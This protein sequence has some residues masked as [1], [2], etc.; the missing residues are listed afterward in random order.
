MDIVFVY[1]SSLVDS[2]RK[3]NTLKYQFRSIAD[4]IPELDNIFFIVNDKTE[5]ENSNAFIG[6]IFEKTFMFLIKSSLSTSNC[7]CDADENIP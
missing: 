5:F 3:L 1:N 6:S 2:V 4:N 7:T